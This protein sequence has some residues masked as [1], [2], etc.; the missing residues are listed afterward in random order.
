[1]GNRWGRWGLLAFNLAIGVFVVLPALAP[2]LEC[3]GLWLP[4]WLIRT[5]YHPLCHQLPSRSLTVCDLPMALCARCFA[6]Y[7]GFWAV[8]ILFNA[9]WFSPW[10]NRL[11]RNPIP[12]PLLIMCLVPMA[13][14]GGAQLV[15]WPIWSEQG[16]HWQALW[17]STNVLRL[18]TGGLAGVGAGAFVYPLLTRLFGEALPNLQTDDPANRRLVPS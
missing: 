18:L 3:H 17:E 14:D 16:V 12:W 4:G 8:G 7:G 6:I 11:P 5:A 1:M 9:L 10:R 2:W 13:L 15:F